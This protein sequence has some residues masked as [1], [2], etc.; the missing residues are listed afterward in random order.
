MQTAVRTVAAGA[1]DA[2]KRFPL[3]LKAS[4]RMLRE[5]LM[6]SPKM[7]T[8]PPS[9]TPSGKPSPKLA[10]MLQDATPQQRDEAAKIVAKLLAIRAKKRATG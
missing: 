8:K 3:T 6:G 1:D 5:P 4:A 7:T 9:K 2:T 10:Q